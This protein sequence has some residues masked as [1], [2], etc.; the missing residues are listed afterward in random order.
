MDQGLKVLQHLKC[1]KDDILFCVIVVA[2]AVVLLFLLM[3]AVL[4]APTGITF[5]GEAFFDNI[6]EQDTII[7]DG[8][9]IVFKS[10]PAHQQEDLEHGVN[11]YSYEFA[12]RS[13]GYTVTVDYESEGGDPMEYVLT[14]NG[15]LGIRSVQKE[16]TA[17]YEPLYLDDHHNEVSGR[18]YI[19]AFSSVSDLQLFIHYDGPGVLRIKSISIMEKRIYRFMQVLGFL[20]CFAVF[21]LIYYFLFSSLYMRSKLDF[22][23]KGSA[24]TALTIISIVIF[25][26][27]PLF[28]GYLF[29]GHDILFHL[30]R[31]EAISAAMHYHRLPIRIQ[32]DL[33]LGFGYS[34]PLYYCDLFLYPFAFL[35]GY[36]FL[37]LRLCYQLYI[38]SITCLTAYTSYRCFM[39]I[40]RDCDIAVTGT[41]LYVL[42]VYRLT[43][44]YL[45]AAVGEYT[46]FAFLPLIVEGLYSIYTSEEARKKVWIPLAIGMGCLLQSHVIS[47]V[48]VTFFILIFFIAKIKCLNIDRLIAFLKAALLAL[49][50]SVWFIVPMLESLS[51]LK[52]VVTEISTRIQWT[53]V[54]LVQ[55]FEVISGGY[56]IS[57]EGT[58]GDMPLGIGGGLTIG[59][60]LLVFYFLTRN[61]DKDRDNESINAK[62][63]RICFVLGMVALWMATVYFPRDAIARLLIGRVEFLRSLWEV[64]EL[65]WRHLT[66]ATMMLSISVAA[67]L[68]VIQNRW[69]KKYLPVLITILSLTLISDL[70]FYLEFANECPQGTFIEMSNDQ[71][72]YMDMS[73]DFDLVWGMTRRIS[74]TSVITDSTDIKVLSYE[75][76]G[77][78]RIMTCSNDG[79]A[80]EAILPLFDFAHYHAYD[81]G[82]GEELSVKRS[83]M[84]ARLEVT[85]PKG[86]D[87][88]IRISYVPPVYWRVMEIISLACW[89]ALIIFG[90]YIL[91]GNLK[92][93]QK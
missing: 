14:S 13:G 89:C 41:A 53:G 50:L 18:V 67:L 66:I 9:D 76:D 91:L 16:S 3:K 19:P 52:P 39:T 15:C 7:G 6:R 1:L 73:A 51:I 71:K 81:M 90:V 68:C 65:V 12:L 42:S 30:N 32:S 86:F 62:V 36:C 70:S 28:M 72:A 87:G 58:T 2:E 33:L 59:F 17:K 24:R 46:A 27:A 38:F 25:A 78:D 21:D 88:S 34:V 82:T 92:N 79:S 61:I 93:G 47:T 63:L 77:A 69:P 57:R 75:T 55:L 80:G 54:Y 29:K 5:K 45:R 20:L 49:G 56:G 35:Y 84:N 48:M 64:M 83:E 22:R 10:M 11:I 8:T 4:G 85:V 31:I 40:F 37:P 44:V 43:D 23:S 74:D 26:S 60:L